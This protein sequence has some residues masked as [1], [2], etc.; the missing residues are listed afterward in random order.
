MLNTNKLDAA[1]DWAFGETLDYFAREQVENL[2]A[3][4]WEWR[5]I[6]Y[7][8]SGQVVGSPRDIIDTGELRDS[9]QVERRGLR[10]RTSYLADHAYDVHE[11]TGLDD[12][13]PWIATTVEETDLKAYFVKRLKE[14]F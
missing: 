4:R 11:G 10:G 5:G 7:R 13:R 3:E 9:L 8:K 6:T 2:K 14:K 12:D 1:I